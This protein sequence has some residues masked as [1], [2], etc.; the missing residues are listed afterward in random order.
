M[1]YTIDYSKITDPVEK[2]AKAIYDI[3]NYLGVPKFKQVCRLV[4][5]D[6]TVTREGFIMSLAIFV[7]IEGYPAEA[8]ADKLG[9]VV[10]KPE[11]VKTSL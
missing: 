8:W 6:Q 2:Q 3:K 9:L 10:A 1:H 11:E 4:H 5:G 7:G